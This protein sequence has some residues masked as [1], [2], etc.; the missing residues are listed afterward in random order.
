MYEVIYLAEPRCPVS[1]GLKASIHA[2]R[3]EGVSP[4]QGCAGVPGSMD[5]PT[6]PMTRSSPTANGLSAS[7]HAPARCLQSQSARSTKH[8]PD[9]PNWAAISRAQNSDEGDGDASELVP[10]TTTRCA[11]RG[12]EGRRSLDNS[13]GPLV[14]FVDD[15]EEGSVSTT[16]SGE[17][18]PDST[19]CGEAEADDDQNEQDGKPSRRTRR[20]R[21]PRQKVPYVPPPRMRNL[22]AADVYATTNTLAPPPP[23]APPHMQHPYTNA[24]PPPSLPHHPISPSGPM[25]IP[26]NGIIYDQFGRPV[27]PHPH[28][29]P[30][31]EPIPGFQPPYPRFYPHQPQP[32]HVFPQ[33]PSTPPYG[34]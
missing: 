34:R 12:H 20:R 2:P 22:A 15:L 24:P 7:M 19:L 11:A 8:H 16:S 28:S 3:N 33:P 26:P 25:M 23:P 18:D 5:T 29:R 27:P 6:P 9:V 14:Y 30:Y 4:A 31:V 32:L 10:T 1:E 17:T 13:D 21:R